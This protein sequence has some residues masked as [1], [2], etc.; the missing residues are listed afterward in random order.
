MAS[1]KG[2]VMR[3]A[4]NRLR[5]R[6][7]LDAVSAAC[8][9]VVEIAERA[10]LDENAVYHCRLAVDE[11]CTNI[12]EHSYGSSGPYRFIDLVCGRQDDQF[13]ITIMDD[14]TAY[15]P[16][17]RPDPDPKSGIEDRQPG[18]WGIYFIKQ[19]MDHV[20]YQRVDNRNH[21]FMVKNIP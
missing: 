5:I 15:N 3:M 4:D 6:G 2:D 12:I 7:I 1:N 18:G 9:F 20:A 8:D 19:F 11:A 16:L 17:L 21:L 13:T 10:G 14:G